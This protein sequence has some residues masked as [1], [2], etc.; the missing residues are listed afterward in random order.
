MEE[1]GA[2][3]SMGSQRVRH[4]LATKQQHYQQDVVEMIVYHFW[5]C[6]ERHNFWLRC[7]LPLSSQ[8]L[9]LITLSGRGQLPHEDNTQTALWSSPCGTEILVKWALPPKK[10]LPPYP[11]PQKHTTLA[12]TLTATQESLNHSHPTSHPKF[13]VHWTYKMRHA[14]YYYKLMS[15]ILH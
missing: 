3:Q 4:N 15:T 1:P 7:S 13:L 5:D 12:D 9:S 11:E 6:Y 14:C 8:P 2:L 10:I